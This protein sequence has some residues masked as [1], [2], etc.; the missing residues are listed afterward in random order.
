MSSR[1]VSIYIYLDQFS[2]LDKDYR[3][4]RKTT[5]KGKGPLHGNNNGSK[6][7]KINLRKTVFL[8]RF[9]FSMLMIKCEPCFSGKGHGK[10]GYPA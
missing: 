9:S 5:C 6:C 8:K 1:H 4:S 2:Y 10:S 7:A 3:D